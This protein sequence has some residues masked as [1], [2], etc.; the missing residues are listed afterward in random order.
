MGLSTFS[1]SFVPSFLLIEL[2]SAMPHP[3]LLR[4]SLL[5]SSLLILLLFT[6]MGIPL[7]LTWGPH[8]PDP[9]YLLPSWPSHSPLSRLM[10]FLLLASNL[11]S[12]ALDSVP[13]VRYCQRT[14]HPSFD[15]H[16]WS[17]RAV[18]RYALLS[19]P[20]FVFGLLAALTVGN[21]LSLLGEH[22]TYIDSVKGGR[23]R[24]HTVLE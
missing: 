23:D 20:T 7:V 21:L 18:L 10:M 11:V 17:C 5:L 3:S 13:L 15:V 6:L 24:L 16:D 4:R 22:L 9:I 14:F 12:Y 2:A 19:L 8:L 1:W